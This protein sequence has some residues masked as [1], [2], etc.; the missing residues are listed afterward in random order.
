M[1]QRPQKELGPAYT[2]RET[3]TPSLWETSSIFFWPKYRVE[4][5]Q[6]AL[7]STYMDRE[8]DTLNRW[9]ASPIFFRRKNMPIR[10]KFLF[11][12]NLGELNKLGTV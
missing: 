10:Q 2:E 6:K 11:G 5:L 3:D 8:T 9:Q 12:E 4:R 1:F 7:E